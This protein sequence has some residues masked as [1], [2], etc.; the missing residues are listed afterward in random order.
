MTGTTS[1]KQNGRARRLGESVAVT[2][3]PVCPARCP[4]SYQQNVFVL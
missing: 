1:K 2:V 4:A 3:T